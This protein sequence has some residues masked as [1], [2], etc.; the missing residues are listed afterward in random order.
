MSVIQAKLSIIFND[1][2]IYDEKPSVM[3]ADSE[4]VSVVLDSNQ[5]DHLIKA[6]QQAKRRHENEVK[7]QKTQR[8]EQQAKRLLKDL[9]ELP[10][11]QQVVSMACDVVWPAIKHLSKQPQKGGHHNE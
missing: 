6:S 10:V 7:R 1:G 2:I 8:V 4:L 3:I 11:K 5:L 9:I